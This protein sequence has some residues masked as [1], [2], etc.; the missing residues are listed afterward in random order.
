MKLHILGCGSALPT[1]QHL[2]TSQALVVRGKVFIIDCGEGCQLSLRKQRISFGRIV[3]I[4][5]SHLH[6]DHTFGLPGLLSTL[7]LTGRNGTL[8]IYGPEGITDY[9]AFIKKQ[10]LDERTCY[11]IEVHEHRAEKKQL[12]Y[13]DNS[14]KV[15]SLPLV[16]RIATTGYLFEEQC[17]ALHLNKA[18]VDFYKIPIADYPNI[19]MGMP[20]LLP[21]GRTIPNH[22]LTT[23]GRKGRSY[24]FCS[25]TKYHPPLA[26]MI[27]GVDLLYHEA[28]YA[29]AEASFA[30]KYYHSTAK[31][32]AR[33]ASS[34]NAGKLLL[35]HFSSRYKEEAILLDEARE[36]FANSQLANEGM[37]I[38][39]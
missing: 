11:P 29:E 13:E 17:T 35:G 5:I 32:A 36:I 30:S 33:I 10:F 9:I 20:Y 34:A 3:A 39:L 37:V 8:H 24:A 2:P 14:L 4:F 38:T 21:D 15:H 27:R 28:T 22:H 16:H 25:D 1:L 23:L 31:E 26:D 6:G 7:A 18:A 12:V 19:L